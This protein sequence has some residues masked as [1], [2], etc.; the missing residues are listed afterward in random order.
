MTA[1]L[2]YESNANNNTLKTAIIYKHSCK[3]GK[4]RL[5]RF[6]NIIYCWT[7]SL[8]ELESHYFYC[9]T[10]YDLTWIRLPYCLVNTTG[11]MIAGTTFKVPAI[12]MKNLWYRK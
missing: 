11:F 1:A 5:Q 4:K 9:G 10:Q 3:S 12:L 2:K 8:P 6:S 7:R